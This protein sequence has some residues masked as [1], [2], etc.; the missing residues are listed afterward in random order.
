[1]KDFKYAVF[2]GGGCRCLWQIG[3]WHSVAPELKLKP[4]IVTGVSAGA[5]MATMIISGTEDIGLQL[6]KE[7][8]A[9]NKKNFYFKNMF[10]KEKVFPHYEIYRNTIIKTFN[11]DALNRLKK[12]PELRVLLTNPPG[13]LGAV[14]GTLLGLMS[15]TI[16]KHTTQPVHPKF[17]SRLG[18][19]PMIIK[20]NDCNTAEEIADMI[21]RSSCTPPIVPIMKYNGKITLD[22]GIIDNVP[23]LAINKDERKGKMLVLMTRLYKSNKIPNDPDIV[24]VQPSKLPPIAKWD[25]TSPTGLQGAYDLGRRD[26]DVFVKSFNTEGTEF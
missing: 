1:M 2:A 25:Y 22:G 18:Y 13:Y 12:G 11:S 4:D 7:A 14:S 19:K 17:A 24:Y 23:V 8:V 21:L 15:Y 10:K 20:L 16:E 3:F 9:A 5:A 6:M 26:G